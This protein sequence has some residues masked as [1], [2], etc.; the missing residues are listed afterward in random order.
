MR[1][2]SELKALL[3]GIIGSG[4]LYFQPP[5]NI[6]MTYPCIVYARSNAD[7]KFADNNPYHYEKRYMITV[8]DKDPDSAIPDKVAGLP[9]CVFDRHY[10]A[11]NLNH[12]VF[13][14]YF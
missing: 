2:R 8:I 5:S 4:A 6:V 14:M 9:A 7:T 1:P 11:D 3:Q 12:D 13:V 10:V